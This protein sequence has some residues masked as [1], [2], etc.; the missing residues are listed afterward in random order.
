MSPTRI[1]ET[2]V[3]EPS[4]NEVLSTFEV[5]SPQ[6]AFQPPKIDHRQ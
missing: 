1:K 5:R 3:V 4:K 2:N 6:L